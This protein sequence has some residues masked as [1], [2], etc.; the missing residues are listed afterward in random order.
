MS[1]EAH[2]QANT[3]AL[4]KLTA[5]LEGGAQIAAPKADMAKPAAPKAVTA[6][7]T[8]AAKPATALAAAQKAA[9]SYDDIKKAANA[10]IVK[11][12]RE[13][14]MKV[15]EGFQLPNAMAA[16]PEQYGELLAAINKAAA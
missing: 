12:G 14:F 7:A 9:A 16:K 15:L 3:V 13:S 2:I 6:P 11:H 10:L 8:P 1:L 5:L 4:L